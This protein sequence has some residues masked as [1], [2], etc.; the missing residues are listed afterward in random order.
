MPTKWPNKNHLTFSRNVAI[1]QHGFYDLFLTSKETP[2][3]F[4]QDSVSQVNLQK[5]QT[6]GKFGIE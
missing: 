3:F 6:G 4:H 1:V 5:T 2:A